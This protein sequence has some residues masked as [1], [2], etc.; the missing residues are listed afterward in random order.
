[1]PRDL[2]VSKSTG[3]GEFSTGLQQHLRRERDETL[4]TAE[5]SSPGASGDRRS[6]PPLLR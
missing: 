6:A 1:M 2:A 4:S 3:S 5:A